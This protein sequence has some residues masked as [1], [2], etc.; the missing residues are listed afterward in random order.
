MIM[1]SGI[2]VTII[3]CSG[4]GLGFESLVRILV[5]DILLAISP[6]PFNKNV[7]QYDPFY[8]P[9]C[10]QRL[11]YI[12]YHSCNGEKMY[13]YSLPRLYNVIMDICMN[14][15]VCFFFSSFLM[16][17]GTM[18]NISNI[19]CSQTLRYCIKHCLSDKTQ[20]M[21]CCDS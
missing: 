18:Y 3:A 12:A 16:L 2:M 14:L 15:Y 11:V 13:A 7:L 8:F 9:C 5:Q 20:S 19:F 17:C 1:S 21:S 4:R 10:F 6:L